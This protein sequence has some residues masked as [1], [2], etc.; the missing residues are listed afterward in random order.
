MDWT[1]GEAERGLDALLRAAE[2]EPQVVTKDGTAVAAII[3][4]DLYREMVGASTGLAE[5]LLAAP[6]GDDLEIVRDTSPL[7]EVVLDA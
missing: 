4:I 7:R 5:H 3:G 1:I 2:D 6:V